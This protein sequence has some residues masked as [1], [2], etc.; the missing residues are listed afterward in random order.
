MPPHPHHHHG[1]HGHHGGGGG[2]GPGWGWGGGYDYPSTELV[3]LDD[4]D[5]DDKRIL[6]YIAS[7]PEKDRAAAFTKFFGGRSM[8]GLGDL[9]A[10]LVANWPFLL[11]GAVALW[12]I[13]R[14]KSNP[15][16]RRRRRRR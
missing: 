14:K 5:R 4:R 3:V 12:F 2:F 7:L 9:Q 11:A 1:H 13:A 10:T 16:R 8:S 15:A 6:A